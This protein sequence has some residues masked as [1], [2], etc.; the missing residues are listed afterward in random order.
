MIEA[1]KERRRQRQRMAV[2]A[3]NAFTMLPHS[4]DI[5]IDTLKSS[6]VF[7]SMMRFGC[8]HNIFT[9]AVA[10]AAIAAVP[11]AAHNCTTRTTVYKQIYTQT[12]THTYTLTHAPLVQP[13][14]V[15]FRIP[16]SALYKRNA[17]GSPTINC[18]TNVLSS[19]S[20]FWC[21]FLNKIL[22]TRRREEKKNKL[23]SCAHRDPYWE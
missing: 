7:P 23:L 12:H 14:H 2:T 19:R 18:K 9:V 16:Y 17:R 3:F 21:H 15:V 1:R 5:T 22:P 20:V 4:C 13:V 8:S 6:I 11:V 10:V